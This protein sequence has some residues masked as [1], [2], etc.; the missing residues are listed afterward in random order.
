M[1]LLDRIDWRYSMRYAYIFVY[2]VYVR[3]QHSGHIWCAEGG[4][5]RLSICCRS[6][7]CSCCWMMPAAVMSA[8][9]SVLCHM[10]YITFYTFT[11]VIL[12]L[13]CSWERIFISVLHT[14]PHDGP[15]F[16]SMFVRPHGNFLFFFSTLFSL[17][18]VPPMALGIDSLD[19]LDGCCGRVKS[20]IVTDMCM[21]NMYDARV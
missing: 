7:I 19:I 18:E 3:F 10:H 21:A 17:V 2:I 4:D 1:T 11:W 9:L 20:K 12:F 6:C 14:L 5:G 13:S 16:V 8:L 15:A